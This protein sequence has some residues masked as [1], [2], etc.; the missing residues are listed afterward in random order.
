MKP[1]PA[2]L[3]RITYLRIETVPANSVE[4]ECSKI[5]HFRRC[6]FE[7]GKRQNKTAEP[8][9]CP[10]ESQDFRSDTGFLTLPS[11][12][13]RCGW[14]GIG[15]E[16]QAFRS[17]DSV[18]MP[19]LMPSQKGRNSK[20]MPFLSFIRVLM[21]SFLFF[22]VL[23]ASKSTSQAPLSLSDLRY[24]ANTI[25]MIGIDKLP[26]VHQVSINL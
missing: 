1:L 2:S 15:F 26:F 9:K 10:T 12:E 3:S 21:W 16:T 4:T 18:S 22:K 7:K 24:Y 25:S 19:G 13:L 14:L 17:V 6:S 11:S 8:S 23:N 5:L 20:F